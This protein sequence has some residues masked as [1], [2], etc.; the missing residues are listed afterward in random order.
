MFQPCFGECLKQ[1]SKQASMLQSAWQRCSKF[2]AWGSV[3]FSSAFA[4]NQPR[5]CEAARKAFYDGVECRLH[6]ARASPGH[7]SQHPVPVSR[8]VHDSPVDDPSRASAR[9]PGACWAVR[10]SRRHIVPVVPGAASSLEV[11]V[12]EVAAPHSLVLQRATLRSK[13]IANDPSFAGCHCLGVSARRWRQERFK[14]HHRMSYS[15]ELH[16][17]PCQRKQLS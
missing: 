3:T 15:K 1:A 5:P 12:D 16:G 6:P 11:A 2:I 14:A 7:A 10:S 8:Q 17:S 9:D 13:M 4:E